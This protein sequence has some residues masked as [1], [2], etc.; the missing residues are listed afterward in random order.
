MTRHWRNDYMNIGIIGYGSI[1][2]LLVQKFADAGVTAPKNIFISNRSKE[3][4]EGLLDTYSVCENNSECAANADV[5]FICTGPY[6]IME[7]YRDILDDL[8]DDTLV[9]SLNEAISFEMIGYFLHHRTAKVIPSLTAE[10]NRSETLVSYNDLVTDKDKEALRSILSS[11]GNVYELPENE[12][13]IASDLVS[14]MPGFIAA[15]FDVFCKQ[16]EK[17]ST[18]GKDQII[19]MVLNSLDA[20]STLINQKGLTFNEVVD[21]VATPG[22]ITVEGTTVIYDKLPDIVDEIYEKTLEKSKT[23]KR[24]V[25]TDC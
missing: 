4:L 22:G 20:S 5:L 17:F 19:K 23:T 24:K 16:A 6:Q 21:R 10:I 1:G 8:K 18:M 2:S 3:K 7:V 11:I 25:I 14:S 15:I 13:A 9:V 12:L